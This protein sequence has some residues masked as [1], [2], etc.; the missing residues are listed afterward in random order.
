V[1]EHPEYSTPEGTIYVGKSDGEKTDVTDTII[2]AMLG[3]FSAGGK[4][5]ILVNGIPGYE[6]AVTKIKGV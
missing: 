4:Y 1:E 5:T 2:R 6:V 3:L